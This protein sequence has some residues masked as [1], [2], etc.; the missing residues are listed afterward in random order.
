MTKV[1]K[2]PT[3]DKIAIRTQTIPCMENSPRWDIFYLIS[4]SFS[5]LYS[6]FLKHLNLGDIGLASL[7]NKVST[8]AY[9]LFIVTNVELP[10]IPY[11]CLYVD[12]HQFINAG[13]LFAFMTLK[14]H[15]GII[16]GGGGQSSYSNGPL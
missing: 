8:R 1:R 9:L 12:E 10:W 15:R 4:D 3:L 6:I 16:W 7:L 11:S 5:L 13:G 2:D 14:A